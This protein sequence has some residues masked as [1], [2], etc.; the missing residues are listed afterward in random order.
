MFCFCPSLDGIGLFVL[1]GIMNYAAVNICGKLLCDY[2]LGYVSRSGTAGS[3][4]N[5]VLNFFNSW[6]SSAIIS[7]YT[8]PTPFFSFPLGLPK[9]KYINNLDFIKIKSFMLKGCH[10][11]SNK[12]CFPRWV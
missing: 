11:E 2:S 12:D 7:S 1:L 5:S 8:L 9:C 10:Q 4:G 6:K 3:Y